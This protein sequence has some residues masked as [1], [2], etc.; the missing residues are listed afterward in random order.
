MIGAK[1]YLLSAQSAYLLNQMLRPLRLKIELQEGKLDKNE[2]REEFLVQKKT[3]NYLWSFL[4]WQKYLNQLP[5]QYDYDF[6]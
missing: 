1:K 4:G 3:S 2:K 5:V 6:L